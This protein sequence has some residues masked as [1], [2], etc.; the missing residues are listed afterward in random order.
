MDI[1]YSG[2]DE[3]CYSGPRCPV[4]LAEEAVKELEGEISLLKDENQE[5]K[6]RLQDALDGKHHEQ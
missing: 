3:V 5:L 4:C 1:C 2:H 6:S